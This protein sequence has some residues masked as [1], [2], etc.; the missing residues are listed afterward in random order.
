MPAD[1][2]IKNKQAW[3]ES[4]DSSNSDGS[5]STITRIVREN[6]PSTEDKGNQRAETL[7]DLIAEGR[8][9][10]NQ[11]RKN[12]FAGK[13]V[14]ERVKLFE[15]QASISGKRG[16]TYA[17]RRED[18]EEGMNVDDPRPP[19]A[20]GLLKAKIRPKDYPNIR[21]S[22]M[23]VSRFL[24]RFE[25]AAEDLDK[26]RQVVNF[27]QDEEALWDVEE[28][29]GEACGEMMEKGGVKTREQY[30]KYVSPFDR[31][32]K[33]LN[34]NKIVTDTPGAVKRTFIKAFLKEMRERA[35]R[36]LFER[37]MVKRLKD[38]EVIVLPDMKEIRKALLGEMDM[39][40]LMEEKGGGAIRSG[41]TRSTEPVT[42]KEVGELADMLKELRLFMQKTVTTQLWKQPE[43]SA[44][45]EASPAG[46][47]L[48][49]KGP[50]FVPRGPPTC[51]YCGV[52]GHF[53]AQCEDLTTDIKTLGVRPVMRDYYLD[54]KKIE[55]AIPRDE[56]RRRRS[57]E[58]SVGGKGKE[59]KVKSH[60]G[61]LERGRVWTP[62]AVSAEVR[63]VEA[64]EQVCFGERYDQ[65]ELDPTPKAE[66]ALKKSKAKEPVARQSAEKKRAGK[67]AQKALGNDT[68]LSLTLK[69]LA[70]ISPLMAEQ[71]IGSIREAAGPLFKETAEKVSA[72]V[73]TVLAEVWSAEFGENEKPVH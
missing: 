10:V 51:S 55:A 12:G 21:F 31:I 39:V 20:M 63:A 40:E 5:G 35:V 30:G 53:K 47:E 50:G 9:L 16:G 42:V 66:P 70:T 46:A 37:N 32:L 45:T 18:S 11:V 6:Q 26:V 62:P 54:G 56:V 1:H 65:M 52:A 15:G 3:N 25:V 41:L 24:E 23:E 19:R 57:T 67:L 49:K 43:G 44:G 7:D 22:T 60:I 34:R 33:Y 64:E 8:S 14:A 38:G 48:A 69:D 17:V 58:N 29:E 68:A 13:E 72:P 4:S 71:L 59:A 2:N 73:E 27:I 28:M 36:Q 61:I